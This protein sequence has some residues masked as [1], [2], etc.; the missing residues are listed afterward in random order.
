MIIDSFDSLH[1]TSKVI[2]QEN[3]GDQHVGPLPIDRDASLL[4]GAHGIRLEH[5]KMSEFRATEAE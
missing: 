3:E 2:Y 1:R 4:Q 5:W